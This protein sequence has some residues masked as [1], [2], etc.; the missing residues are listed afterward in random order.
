[1]GYIYTPGS[2][3][4]DGLIIQ[5]IHRFFESHRPQ[6]IGYNPRT[7]RNEVSEQAAG[8]LRTKRVT[9]AD[10]KRLVVEDA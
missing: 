4:M 1:M 5:A 8:L 7:L 10:N 9:V 6:F 2:D 3:N